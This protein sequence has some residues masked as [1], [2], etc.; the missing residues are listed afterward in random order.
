VILG[1]R[2]FD[3]KMTTKYLR[4]STRILILNPNSSAAMTHGVEEA[5]R[6][7]DL[8]QAGITMDFIA[9]RTIIN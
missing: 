2:E 8:A 6:S 4:R 5:I 7:I 1:K 3:G 9:A